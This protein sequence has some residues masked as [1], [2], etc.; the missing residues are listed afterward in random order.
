MN[1][2]NQY[3]IFIRSSIII[4]SV[5]LIFALILILKPLVYE[6]IISNHDKEK[7]RKL[8]N[9]YGQN[10]IS[11]VDIENDKKYFFGSESQGFIAYITV[12]GV[13]VCSVILYVVSMICQCSLVNL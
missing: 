8:L 7:V 11:Y 4:N 9:T 5:F 10:P 3:D 6:P 2:S 13:A 1:Y 12:E